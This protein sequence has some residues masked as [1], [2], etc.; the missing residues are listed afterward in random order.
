MTKIALAI[1]MVALIVA[2]WLYKSAGVQRDF[3]M[4]QIN[5]NGIE[6]T[7]ISFK[8]KMISKIVIGENELVWVPEGYGWYRSGSVKKLLQNENKMY[9]LDKLVLYGLGF[10]VDMWVGSESYNLT[11]I[12]QWGWYPWL[13]YKMEEGGW[14]YKEENLK[15]LKNNSQLIDKVML[16]D[17]ADSNILE[18]DIRVVVYNLTN[19]NGLAE[20]VGKDIERLGF[21][22]TGWESSV[23]E[24]ILCR[25]V[26]KNRYD[27]FVRHFEECEMKISQDMPENE[28]EIYFGEKFAQMINYKSYVGT[29]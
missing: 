25:I 17:M 23:P 21:A 2:V 28:I 5:D 7:S 15:D 1:I 24:D 11:M 27:I 10:D 13:K 6:L 20:F 3:R 18:S 16:R 22:V 19:E 14:L 4:A 9:L 29:F 26:S 12:K 8:R